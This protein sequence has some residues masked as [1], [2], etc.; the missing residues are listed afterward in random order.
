[1]E[2][3]LEFVSF[4]SVTLFSKQMV[5]VIVFVVSL[6]QFRFREKDCFQNKLGRPANDIF[7]GCRATT[8]CVLRGKTWNFK[9]KNK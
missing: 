9:P 8:G 3:F 7:G 2:S 4:E 1:M 6:L 5:C